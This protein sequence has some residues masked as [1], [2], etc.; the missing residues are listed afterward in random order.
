MQFFLGVHMVNWL[1]TAAVPLFVS[2]RRLRPRKSFPRAAAPWALD[3]GGFSEISIHGKWQT[4]PHQYAE[5]A[6]LWQ[7]EIGALAW[8]SIQD[9]MCEPAMLQKTGLTVQ[10]HQRR[11]TLNWEEL[12]SL[13]PDVPWTP[14]LQGWSASDYMRHLELYAR[15]G[16]DLRAEAVVGLGTMC[17]RQASAEAAEIVEALHRSGLRLHAFGFKTQGLPQTM[18][19]LVSSDSMSWSYNAR[20]NPG[21]CPMGRPHKCANCLPFALRWRERLL[22]KLNRPAQLS[23]PIA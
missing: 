1:E 10:E 6:R 5:E 14:V 18:H 11:S 12:K 8:A 15:R 3:S 21:T 9:W 2:A 22:S 13:A 16:H 7:Q 23:L 17:R 19:A 4:P 20:R